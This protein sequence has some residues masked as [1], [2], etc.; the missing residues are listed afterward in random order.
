MGRGRPKKKKDPPE[1]SIG[2]PE[3]KSS[4]Q[5]E[6]VRETAARSNKINYKMFVG[7]VELISS[8]LIN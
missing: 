6:G 4:K 2:E 1:A 7:K 5:Q 3:P 8:N